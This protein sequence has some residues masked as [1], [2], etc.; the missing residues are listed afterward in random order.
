MD[1]DVDFNSMTFLMTGG[2]LVGSIPVSDDDSLEVKMWVR[3][4]GDFTNLA[5]AAS[6]LET[7]PYWECSDDNQAEVTLD[8]SASVDELN[9]TDIVSYRWIEDAGALTEI[10]LG[11]GKTL[12]VSMNYGIHD[13][14]LVVTD[15]SGV[16]TSL[17]AEIEV[18]DSRID[19]IVPPA[20]VYELSQGGAGTTV[21]PGT[22]R[23]DDNCSGE[24]LISSDAPTC[25][26][27]PDG[28]S[29]IVWTFDDQRGNL[30]RHLQRVFVLDQQFF[31][32]PVSELDVS[33]AI[34]PTG[35]SVH[36]THA[37]Y[38]QGK[39]MLLDEYIVLRA[40]DGTES[41]IDSANTIVHGSVVARG[42]SKNYGAMATSETVYSDVLSD[43]L[44]E[45][46]W[47]EVEATLV[48]PGGASDDPTVVVACSSAWLYLGSQP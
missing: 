21:C 12:T 11:S 13:I 25:G 5:P 22:A 37:T 9:P 31:P 19:S 18:G 14:T 28:L 45:L 47:Y 46:G 2:P 1:L 35:S 32:P 24:V 6:L 20:D 41:S 42:S 4:E 39:G 40:P 15:S 43:D 3:L 44:T 23:A 10:A 30:E 16:S 36:I 29:E 34:V 17:S 26:I 48:E 27:F 8:A 7:E 33:P 38:P